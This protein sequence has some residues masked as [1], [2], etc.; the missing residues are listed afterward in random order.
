MVKKATLDQYL[1]LGHMVSS[2][3][4]S[5]ELVQALIEGR[6]AY[7]SSDPITVPKLSA[8]ELCRLAQKKFSLKFLC[9]LLATWDF[10]GD[11]CG[12]TYEVKTWKPGC[13]VVPATDAREH[14]K[15]GF[16]GNTAAF[17]A[18]MVANCPTGNY[19]SIPED[20]RLFSSFKHGLSAP[21]FSRTCTESALGVRPVNMIC[22]EDWTFVVFRLLK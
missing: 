5:P 20:E 1:Q 19:M 12:N 4:I 8:A 21:G 10:V 17:I 16:T 6:V 13:K 15:D 2:G 22:D 14:F 3:A 18:W 7:K 9:T 11:E